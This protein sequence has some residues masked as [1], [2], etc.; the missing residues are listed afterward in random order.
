MLLKEKGQQFYYIPI[1]IML[2]MMIIT[3]AVAPILALLIAF[4]FTL[5]RSVLTRRNITISLI[6]ALILV[7]MAV[8]TPVGAMLM[9]RFEVLGT[10]SGLRLSIWH[11]TLGRAFW[12]SPGWDA[13]LITSSISP[14]T[15]VN[16]SQP[17]TVFI[18]GR[19]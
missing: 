13:A 5:H 3:K 17:P 1:I 11:H 12:P 8:L 14:T 18:W 9:E 16:T 10:Q 7:A 4:I 15:A 19:C 6:I 2:I